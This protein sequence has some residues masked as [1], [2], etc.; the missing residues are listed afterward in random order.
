MTIRIGL[1]ED[2]NMVVDGL[3]AALLRYSDLE[4][5]A[6]GGTVEEARALLSR[7]DLDVVLLDVRLEDGNGLQLL[8]EREQL[9]RP[10]VLVISAFNIVQYAAAAA[11]FGASGFVLKAVPLPVLV[12]AI[13]VIA[14][15]G[16]VFGVEHLE[17]RFVSL[18]ARERV[19][20][21]FAME[22]L[23]NKEI[24]ARLGVHRK[25]VEAHLSKIF[26]KYHILGGRIDLSIHAA[27]EGWLDIQPPA[28]T[29][30]GRTVAGI[31]GPLE[32]LR[33]R[34][35]TGTKDPV[36]VELGR[37]GGLRGGPATARRLTA[38][39]RSESARRAALAR[40]RPT[41]T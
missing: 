22:G 8:A 1:V 18:T 13:R 12:G 38:E 27:Q 31:R 25:T 40:W 17:R 7:R 28:G 34:S 4:L 39:Q 33:D 2:H 19:I 32:G 29:V 30:D 41:A 5:V 26:A 6:H 35:R 10:R 9:D 11:R 16:T 21:R 15:D 24:G 20:L 36:A 23:S 3:E 37:R 14:D